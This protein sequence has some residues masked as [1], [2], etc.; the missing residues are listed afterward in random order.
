MTPDP[1]VVSVHVQ[2]VSRVQS[3]CVARVVH[4][5]LQVAVVSD[6]MHDDDAVHAADVARELQA[7]VQACVCEF[8]MQSASDKH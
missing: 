2:S 4:A 3:V 7:A 8:H 6:H 5:F 1:R